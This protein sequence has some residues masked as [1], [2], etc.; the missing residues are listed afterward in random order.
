MPT[1]IRY[2]N[3]VSMA[4]DVDAFEIVTLVTAEI[5]NP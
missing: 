5:E 1:E 4:V 2:A 3:A